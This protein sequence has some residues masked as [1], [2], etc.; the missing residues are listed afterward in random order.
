M[1]SEWAKAL[2]PFAV[3]R[4]ITNGYLMNTPGVMRLQSAAGP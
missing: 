2:R 1:P 4:K 3:F